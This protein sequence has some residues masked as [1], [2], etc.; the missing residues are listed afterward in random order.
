MGKRLLRRV[1]I[2]FGSISIHEPDFGP[3]AT[4]TYPRVEAD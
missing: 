1:F 4:L 3:E 2:E